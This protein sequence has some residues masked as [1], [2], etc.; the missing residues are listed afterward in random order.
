M[1]ASRRA[2]GAGGAIAAILVLLAACGTTNYNSDL[3]AL[4]GAVESASKGHF[5]N[6]KCAGLIPYARQKKVKERIHSTAEYR[7]YCRGETAGLPGSPAPV[8]KV[9]RVTTD[10]HHWHENSVED[11]ERAREEAREKARQEAPG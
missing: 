3:G 2:I 6:V 11:A 9:I 8:T 5:V 10:G 7:Y 1:P 4:G